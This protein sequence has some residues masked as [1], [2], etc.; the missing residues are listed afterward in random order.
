M[1][2]T[3]KYSNPIF[4]LYEYFD[5]DIDC[6]DS[7]LLCKDLFKIGNHVSDLERKFDE[8][9]KENEKLEAKNEKLRELVEEAYSNGRKDELFGI[10][11]GTKKIEQK[12]KEIMEE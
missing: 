4:S 1:G 5:A 7:K 2:V 3:S 10:T 12:L 9:R 11:T 8:E 6:E